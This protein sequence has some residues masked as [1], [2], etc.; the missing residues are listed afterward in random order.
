MGCARG[1]L[2]KKI[3]EKH[4]TIEETMFMK[5]RVIATREERTMRAVLHR[6]ISKAYENKG[7]NNE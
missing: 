1:I 3:I 6:L 2:M 7:L 5:L 4:V